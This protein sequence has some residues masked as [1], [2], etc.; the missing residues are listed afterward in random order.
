M[1]QLYDGDN[2]LHITAE[3]YLSLGT[4]TTEDEQRP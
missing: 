4:S 1:G 3:K 2:I